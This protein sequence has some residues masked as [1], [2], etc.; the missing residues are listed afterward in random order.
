MKGCG[1][2]REHRHIVCICAPWVP[3]K[4]GA[5]AEPCW[6]HVR[7]ANEGR[8]ALGP[9]LLLEGYYMAREPLHQ[10]SEFNSSFSM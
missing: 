8:A 10:W 5:R 9:R 2:P 7:A 6:A 1:L 4:G 3:G